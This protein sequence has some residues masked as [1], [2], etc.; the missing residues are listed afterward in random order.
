[1]LD[2]VHFIYHFKNNLIL[3]HTPKMTMEGFI[4]FIILNSWT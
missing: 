1:M 4:I 2:F 3:K